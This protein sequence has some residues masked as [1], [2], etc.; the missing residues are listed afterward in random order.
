[1]EPVPDDN[2]WQAREGGY[3]ST[4]FEIDWDKQLA[5]CPHGKISASWSDAMTR[6]ER[7]VVKIKFRRKDC[8]A[9]DG[10]EKCARNREKRRTLTLL[11]PQAH[12]DTQQTL[13]RRQQTVS[14]QEACKVRAGVEGKISQAAIAFNSRRSRYR[15]TVKT[16]LQHLA[17]AAAMNL[18]RVLDW[19]NE[20]P[21]SI[22]PTSHFAR[23]APS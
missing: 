12:Y 13:R 3:D 9:Y 14:F 6:S 17:T 19:L 2:S 4:Q 1:M 10:L 21:R 5:T 7:P 11:A 20:V 16:H 23:L 15:S 8:R 18:Y 22:T